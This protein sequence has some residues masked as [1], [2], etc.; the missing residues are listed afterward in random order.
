MTALGLL[1]IGLLL[2][3]ILVSVPVLTLFFELATTLRRPA[4]TS[5]SSRPKAGPAGSLVVLMPAHDEAE[6]IAASIGT[7][8]AQ[9]GRGD[10]LLVVA[11]NC[12]DGTAEVARAAGAEVVERTDPTRRGKGYA[13]DFGVR[14]LERG[15]PPSMVVIVDADCI[16]APHALERLAARCLAT[17]RPVQALYTM[18]A[19]TGAGIGRRI[20]AF[21]WLVKNK[22]RPSG[23][24]AWGL[25]CQLMGTGMAFPWSIIRAAPLATGHLVEDMQLGIDLAMRGVAPVFCE[26]AEVWSV[27]PSDSEGAK[28]Q[29]T[30]WEHGH[31]SVMASAGPRLLRAA[32][33][34]RDLSLLVMALDL[35]VPPLASLVLALALVTALDAVGAVLGAGL[36]PIAVVIVSWALLLTGVLVAWQRVGRHSVSLAELLTLP[37]YILAKVPVYL[38]LFT[39]RQVDWVRTKRDDRRH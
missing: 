22:L 27:F 1:D 9:C 32:I 20:A 21:A 6:G 13:L 38:R 14:W 18:R 19:P 5:A 25:P 7:V 12:T 24:A 26:D 35:L 8:R 17:G 2:V 37:I 15:E 30:R 3:S 31:L 16:L 23:L 29:R 10:R 39:K 28:S 33:V 4:L 36:G 34:G 11:D